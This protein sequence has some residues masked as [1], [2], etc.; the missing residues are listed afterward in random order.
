MR[1]HSVVDVQELD[2]KLEGSHPGALVKGVAKMLLAGW[3]HKS[4]LPS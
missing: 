1:I 3:C 4:A 2:W